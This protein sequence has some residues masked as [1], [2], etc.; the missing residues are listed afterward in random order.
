MIGKKLKI[1]IVISI[2]VI[3]GFVF[4]II[5]NNPK[6]DVN[7][8]SYTPTLN[9]SSSVIEIGIDHVQKLRFSKQD[10]SWSF[11]GVFSYDGDNYVR[12]AGE[13]SG[14]LIRF[15][16]ITYNRDHPET[17]LDGSIT[18]IKVL[19][20][21][22]DLKTIQINS[23]NVVMEISVERNNPYIG[24]KATL[25]SYVDNEL[26]EGQLGFSLRSIEGSFDFERGYIATRS[27]REDQVTLPYAFPAMY[28]ELSG[29]DADVQY[30]IV[31]NRDNTSDVFNHIRRKFIKNV[32][33]IGVIS[34]NAILKAN[35]E[36]TYEDYLLFNAKNDTN[37]YDLIAASEQQLM[38][39]S[40]ISYVAA[41]NP[42]NR[43]ANSYNP[44]VQ[45]L[46]YDLMDQRSG[47]DKFLGGMSPYAYYETGGS[48]GEAFAALDVLKGMMRYAIWLDN[49]EVIEK[50]TEMIRDFVIEHDGNRQWIVPYSG[51]NAKSDEFFL[52]NQYVNGNFGQNDAGEETGNIPGI[53]TWK[54]YDRVNNLG[55]LAV[56]TQDPEIIAGYMSLIPFIRTLNNDD[57]FQPVAYF[58]DTREPATGIEGGGSAGGT[59]MWGYTQLLAYEL[60][61]EDD[62]LKETYLEDAKGALD[63]AYNLGFHQMY[64][65]RTDLKPT[66]IGWT[67]KGSVKLYELT[68][69][70][71]FLEQ[72]ETI[73][74]GIYHFYYL[75]TNPETYF[76][77]YGF[78]YAD[79]RER[80]E[81][82]LEMSTSLWL[83]S[84]LLPYTENTDLLQ[85]FYNASQ[86]HLWSLP[87]NGYPYGNV[88]RTLDSLDALYIPYE[89][90][91]GVLGDN[92]AHDGGSQSEMRQVKQI[93]GSGEVFLQHQM[94]DA[95]GQSMD[96]EVLLINTSS[97]HGD[98]KIDEQTFKV[99]N[100]SIEQ[101]D[102]V[103]YFSK[104]PEGMYEVK[105]QDVLLGTYAS[106]NLKYGIAFSILGYE[107]GVLTVNR[108]SDEVTQDTVNEQT[109][110][111]F[112]TS[113]LE[114]IL[115]FE[116]NSAS[117]LRID[118]SS[119]PEFVETK[120]KSVFTQNET[121]KL[122][123]D[124]NKT[125]YVR[126]TKITKDGLP[127][128]TSE[129]VEIK[130]PGIKLV[131]KDDFA[132]DNT[133]TWT[134]ENFSIDHDGHMAILQMDGPRVGT[135]KMEK[136]YEN[137][138]LDEDL[139]IEM[140]FVSKNA[141]HVLNMTATI[142]G[143]E[144][145]IAKDVTS[146]DGHFLLNI[147]EAF[148]EFQGE[149]DL[150][151]TIE[152]VGQNRSFALDRVRIFSEVPNQ[153]YLR[154]FEQNFTSLYATNVF[155][156]ALRIQN[157][158]E[159][160]VTLDPNVDVNFDPQIYREL[161]IYFAD[162]RAGDTF[163]LRI[164]N[165]NGVSLFEKTDFLPVNKRDGLFYD[166]INAGLTIEDTYNISYQFSSGSIASVASMNLQ[167]P[168]QNAVSIDASS[169][170]ENG[171]SAH[172]DSNDIL[173]IRPGSAYHYGEIKKTITVD[174]DNAPI[175]TVDIDALVGG[176]NW[177]MK[178][179]PAGVSS[180]IYVIHDNGNTGLFSA[181]L[182]Q[183]I[184]S[185]GLVEV[186]FKI[187]IIAPSPSS[188]N[189][190]VELGEIAFR[191]SISL[192][193]TQSDFVVSETS[194]L[195]PQANIESKPYIVVDV[196]ELSKGAQWRVYVR[197]VNTNRLYELK[198]DYEVRYPDKYN[199]SKLGG[200]WYDVSDITGLVGQKDIEIVIRLY[201]NSANI[202]IQDIYFTS[203]NL[204]PVVYEE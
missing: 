200:Y 83:M 177:A 144:V 168:T 133:N 172:L 117:H 128:E 187:F 121:Y 41:T 38:H 162:V 146:I 157:D 74:N 171:V 129:V 185:G 100:A 132:F 131:V 20:D 76:P 10:S 54:Y 148:S 165:S 78:G 158:Q 32:Y 45:G 77:T 102:T 25:I 95:W 137:I 101:K 53:S 174:L 13:E 4:T 195:V 142:Q 198:S 204:L 116:L 186:T 84:N 60:A 97:A 2:V 109:T 163:T 24:R 108:T 62:P 82:Y 30:S 88:S 112:T 58:Y 191:D 28:G 55:E 118:I 122:Y 184:S 153:D 123:H 68:K 179:Q 104:M 150:K 143:K 31:V 155:T 69:D 47:Y 67:V 34:S 23:E 51:E 136:T 181:D 110:F 3:I 35:E 71:R 27:S 124:H 44:V 154:F 64:G 22:N 176:A 127:Y 8:G 57:Y 99:F 203:D 37:M 111:T 16:P 40:N 90:S 66:A 193:S 33:E 1:G 72:A 5:M 188:V 196:R 14:N 106:S 91:T 39:I 86:T 125:F 107:Q 139:F 52:N 134:L 59:A 98:L 190:G 130:S 36:Y 49:E 12:V 87:I 105:Y 119:S 26:A 11:E 15:N 199:R 94:F 140:R 103:L 173:R 192:V 73:A 79:S 43:Q 141:N 194:Y 180:D 166:L 81:A 19:A 167:G 183:I 197:D 202:T 147:S 113:S 145:K 178:V 96:R 160:Q 182:R 80:W 126:A 17:I 152:A 85:L 48:W 93:Y 7:E 161:S 65:M 149:Q 151:V 46:Y 170:W 75:Q 6:K 114:T 70:E 42:G 63:R 138:N 159:P 50:T 135:S 61:G 175:V 21:G 120:T 164:E 189:A 56:L 92:P 156:N 169:G 89:F 29:R 201:G 18:D 9:T 115:H